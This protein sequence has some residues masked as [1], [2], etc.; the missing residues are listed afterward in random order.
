MTN[1]TTLHSTHRTA[2]GYIVTDSGYCVVLSETA[3]PLGEHILKCY[4]CSS[5]KKFLPHRLCYQFL[6]VYATISA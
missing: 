1:P 5:S 4:R 2:L 6:T 3:P